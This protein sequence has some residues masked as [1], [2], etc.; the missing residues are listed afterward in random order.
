MHRFPRLLLAI[1]LLVLLVPLACAP[2]STGAPGEGARR[3][4]NRITTQ[5]IDDA[6]HSDAYDLVRRLRPRWLQS[7]GARSVTQTSDIVV[8]LDNVQIGGPRSLRDIQ[9]S[10]VAELVYLD[11]ATATQ[12]W[13]TGHPYGAILVVTSRTPGR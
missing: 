4:P 10:S 11:P 3:D 12:R 13:G 5:E 6:P 7:R 2:A 8:Y 1:P 9:P